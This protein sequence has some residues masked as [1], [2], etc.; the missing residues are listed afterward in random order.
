[1]VGLAVTDA[2]LTVLTPPGGPPQDE[3]DLQWVPLL[4]MLAVS[5]ALAFLTVLAMQHM[6]SFRADLTWAAAGL[7]VLDAFLATAIVVG[8]MS[9]DAVVIQ[10]ILSLLSGHWLLTFVAGRLAW[11]RRAPTY[12]PVDW[13]TA[14]E[15]ED[16]R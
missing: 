13:V 15:I 7:F 12:P 16:D 10:T 9:G 5:T 14:D 11:R 8:P 6:G 4:M 3:S 2:A 1:M